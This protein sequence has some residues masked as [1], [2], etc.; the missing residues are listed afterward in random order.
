[1]PTEA[2]LRPRKTP[3]QARSTA[4]VEAILS[5][6]ARVLAGQG[7]EGFNTNRVAEVA[8]VSIGSLYQYFPNKAA[9]TAALIAR[10]QNALAAGLEQRI[11]ALAGAPLGE[12][13]ADLARLAVGQQYGEAR[14]AAAL[15]HEEQRLSVA[16]VAAARSRMITA[17]E[18]LLDRHRQDLAADLSPRAAA[19]CLTLARALVEA[20]ALAGDAPDP[21]LA[22]RV[23]R[24][25]LGYLTR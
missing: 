2:T 23:E 25:I 20:D 3:R 16:E 7:L 19:D 21:D 1:M 5:A 8:G 4:T 11:A 14:L 24:A 18:T 17:I 13:V 10:V 22:L 9:L 15:D 6:A 12:A